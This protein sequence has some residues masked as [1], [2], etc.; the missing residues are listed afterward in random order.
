MAGVSSHGVRI[1]LSVRR[2]VPDRYLR[3]MSGTKYLTT[4]GLEAHVQLSTKS[5]AFCADRNLFGQ[6]PNR[7]ISPV[8][9][10]YP[11]TLP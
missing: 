6:E 3:P 1:F 11:G 4:I 10:G 2:T 9:L 8:S 5:K 7:N